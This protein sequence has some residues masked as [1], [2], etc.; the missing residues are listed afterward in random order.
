MS[1]SLI[2]LQ[3]I[4]YNYQ[5]TNLKIQSFQS[6][7]NDSLITFIIPSINRDTLLQ[8]LL[9]IINQTNTQWKAIL[10][11][12]GCEPS[13]PELFHLLQDDRFLY[14]SIHKTGI[15]SNTNNIH[16]KAGFVRN[17]GMQLV[18]TPWIGLV[19]DDDTLTPNYIDTLINEY[20]QTPNADLILFRMLNKIHIY[21][22]NQLMTIERNKVGISFC[23]QTKLVQEGFRFNQSQNEDFEFIHQIDQAHKIIVISSEITYL[24]GKSKYL[25]IFSPRIVLNQT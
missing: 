21:P 12:D 3:T 17:I 8:T 15:E 5:E 13:S 16:G 1:S 25:P 18:T 9:S 7:H 22:P 6:K 20:H 10:I 2:S 14:F 23:F 19:D 11:F 24:V 4:L